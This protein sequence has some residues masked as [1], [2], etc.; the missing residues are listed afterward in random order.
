[1]DGDSTDCPWE[2]Q[3]RYGHS[4]TPDEPVILEE[5]P[6]DYSPWIGEHIYSYLLLLIDD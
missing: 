3:G 2:D 6:D 1:M 5:N 4:L